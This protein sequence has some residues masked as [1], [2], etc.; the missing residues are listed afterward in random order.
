MACSGSC[1]CGA[2]TYEISSDVTDTGACHCE[3]CRKWSGG[4]YLGVE[5]PADKLSISGSENITT[6]VS[7]EWAE[8]GFCKTCGS[9]LYYRITAHG[10]YHGTFYVSMGTLDQTDGIDLKGEVFIDSK[11]AGYSF[12]QDTEKLT[13]AELMALFAAPEGA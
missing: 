6:F 10:P 11:P 8:R 4:V 12:A 7:S 5:V 2:V 13:G 3:M 1:L 9:S